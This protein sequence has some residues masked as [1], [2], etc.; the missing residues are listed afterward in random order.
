MTHIEKTD[1]IVK[2]FGTL[3]KL[4][5]TEQRLTL[6]EVA[7]VAGISR[8]LV[9]RIEKGDIK[10]SIGNIIKLIIILEIRLSNQAQIELLAYL[11]HAE[12]K[13][14]LLPKSVRKR[15]IDN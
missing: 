6:Q 2:Q 11:Q 10:C 15:N 5:R 13:L 1:Q 7:D 14:A 12:E 9:Q 8:G 4:S 3:I